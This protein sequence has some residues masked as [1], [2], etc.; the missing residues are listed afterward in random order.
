[1][2]R[3][4]IRTAQAVLFNFLG[5]EAFSAQI[6]VTAAHSSIAQKRD[7][8]KPSPMEKVPRNE[9]DEVFEA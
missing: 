7:L 1:M 5:E 2:S 6:S 3:K 9:A 8:Q 4:R